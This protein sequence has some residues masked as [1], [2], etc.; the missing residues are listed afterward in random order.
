[1]ET[2]KPQYWLI[3]L[4]AWWEGEVCTRHLSEFFQISRQQASKHLHAYQ[5]QHPDQLHYQP[6]R[7]RYVPDD[8]FTPEHISGD[9]NEYLNWATGIRSLLPSPSPLISLPHFSI[10][11]PPRQVSNR[12]MRVLVKALRQQRRLEVDYLSVSSADPDGRI[13]VPHTFV[14]TGLR[15]HLRAWCEKNRSYRDFVLSRFR[16]I[17]ELL[18]PSEQGP[19]QDEAWNTQVRLILQPDPRLSAAKQAVIAQDYNMTDGQLILT[20]RAALVQYLLQEMQ[21]SVKM[22]DGTPEAQQLVLV[23]ADELRPW[24]F[25]A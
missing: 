14:N 1:M 16:G 13:I 23:N 15:W 8:S 18:D 3:E 10:A 11:P 6:S 5:V 2:G 21:V 19:E 22:L 4:L 12:V 25:N 17:P 9:V 7:K 24:L 20:T